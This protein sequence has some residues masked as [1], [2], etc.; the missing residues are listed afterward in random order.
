MIAE[1]VDTARTLAVAL[2]VWIAVLS[3]AGTLAVWTVA[4]GAWWAWRAVYRFAG[5]RRRSGARLRAEVPEG[6]PRA[7]R[8]SDRRPAP[9]WVLPSDEDPE[10][11]KPSEAA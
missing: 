8:P 10:V 6:A 5:A 1:A 4:V 7:L 3:A 11:E 9:R 2:L